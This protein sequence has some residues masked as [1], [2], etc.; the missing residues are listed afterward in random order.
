MRD[1]AF[2]LL[3]LAAFAAPATADE[4]VNN[5]FFE[6]KV[7]PVLAAHCVDCH[8]PKKDKGGLRL[9]T[10]ANFAKGG[11]TGPAVVAGDPDKSLLVRVVRYTDDIKMPPKRKLDDADI[12]TLTAWVKGGAPWPD[13]GGAGAKV[14]AF[15]VQARA[16]AHWSFRPITRPAAP[17]VR[18]K[19]AARGDIDRFLLAKLDAAG[20]S[21]APPAEKRTL[22]RRVHFDLIGLPPTP[23]EVEAFVADASPDAFEKVVEKLLASPHYGE[24]WGRHWL[25]LVRYAETSGH[26]FDFEIPEAWRYRD[27]VVRALNADLPYD[28]FL[29]EHIA[30]DLLPQPRRGRDGANEA[31]LATGFWWLGEAKHSPV[32]SRAEH[33]DRID[34]QIDVF[35]KTVL[36]LTISCARCHDHKFD[37]IATRDYYSLFSVLASSRMDR[38][39]VAD[40]A[41]AV[42][43]LDELRAARAE[44]DA[45]LATGARKPPQVPADGWRTKAVPFE[46][47]GDGWRSRW[48]ASGL[49][50]RSGAAELVP[51]PHS[52]Q[53]VR[54]LAGAV[55]SPTFTI[56][57]PFLAVRIAGKDGK[58]RLVLN[59]L[60]LIQAPIYGGLAQPV[61]HGDELRWHVIDLKMWKGQTAYL[62]LLDDGPGYVAISEAWFSDTPPHGEL[63]ARVPLPELPAAPG[64]EA[65]PLVEKIRALEAAVPGAQRALTIRDGTGIDERVFIRGSH[66]TPGVPAP[67]GFL[68]AFAKPPFAGPGSGRL[69]LARAVTDPTNPL[70]A[71]VIV[72]RL[73]KHHFGEGIVRSP[74][75]FGKQGQPPTHPELLDWL[76]SEL[77]KPTATP[78]APWSLKR[79]HRLMVLSTAY[80]Q[81]SRATPEQ[82]AKAVTADP[83]NKLLHHQNVRR[84]EAEAIR[85][86]L[87][88]VSGRLDPA[89]GGPGVLPHLTEHQVGRG[90]PA[91]GPLDGNGR[92][93]VYLA[94][95]RNF[96]NPMFQAFDYPTPFTAIGRRTVSNVPA[97]ALV[98]M[99]NPFVVQQA[100]LWA[101]RV[102]ASPDRTREQRVGAMYAAA[103]GRPPTAAELAAAAAFLAEQDKE[104]GKPD[105]PKAWAD[106]A[107]VLVNAKEFIFVE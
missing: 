67:R 71:R 29:T 14:E 54:K 37:P 25:D 5:E 86:T 15:D 44:L 13:D 101:K 10:R 103:F 69:E 18:D 58:V 75:D 26:E 41:A 48:D 74:D 87:L 34:N 91:S 28:Q 64:P 45:L 66:K 107:H 40:P 81:S 19:P 94:V 73:W 70:V 47:F 8:G 95:R 99:N 35:G 68:E 43:A 20:L 6:K 93:S 16:K 60:Q 51:Y 55:R 12:A 23:A 33:A 63:G 4:P 78:G 89:V 2:P 84:L 50:F 62:E 1:V 61:N 106:L 49:A 9:D 77:V 24:R 56:D 96:L 46:T 52:G 7:R 80:R 90:R 53:E 39:D 83:Q 21:F 100:E 92:R 32:D 88:S 30:G 59:G 11:D 3:A 22:L 97:Q 57:K 17:D 76:A 38:G 31:L 102:L 98:M 42:K 72:N 36:G 65:K 82:A 79:M 85:D 104:Y 27:Y 105:A